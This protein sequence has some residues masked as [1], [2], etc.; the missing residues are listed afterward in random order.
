[1]GVCLGGLPV[2]LRR[3]SEDVFVLSGGQFAAGDSFALV[4]TSAQGPCPFLVVSAGD[5]ADTGEL[6]GLVGL[7]VGVVL[8]VAVPRLLRLL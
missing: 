7:L 5:L 8:A 4:T 2:V 1:M 6:F 3:E